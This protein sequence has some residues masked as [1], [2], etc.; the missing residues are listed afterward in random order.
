MNKKNDINSAG[1]EDSI[2]YNQFNATHSSHN[3]SQL[4][5]NSLLPKIPI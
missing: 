3:T 5:I 2:I 1:Q 4:S